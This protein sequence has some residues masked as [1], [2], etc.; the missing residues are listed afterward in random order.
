MKH[1]KKRNTAF[2]F[3]C[4]VQEMSK[5]I[6]SKNDPLK[7]SISSV[8]QEFFNKKSILS[9]ELAIYQEVLETRDVSKETASK[10]LQEARRAHSFL[11]KKA[12]FIKQ[13][14]LI[15]KINKELKPSILMNEISDFKNIASLC[16]ILYD[17]A[18]IKEK[19]FLEEQ[20]ADLLSSKRE[21][22]EENK[23]ND[24]VDPIVLPVAIK[25]FNDKY[26]NSLKTNQKELL[27]RFI[28]LSEGTWTEFILYSGSEIERIK[29]NIEIASTIKE[30][31][32]LQE[33]L[34]KVSQIIEGF[35]HCEV[36]LAFVD[37]LLKLQS[38]EAEIVL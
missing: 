28:N 6:V 25:K 33:E 35:E 12:I 15:Q 10:I 18:S 30:F 20:L 4:L 22:L 26:S 3:E 19:I 14:A 5:A 31:E 23:E 9:K 32:S 17:S 16:Q 21:I 36:N 38:L 1:N 27:N 7:Q 13:V 34:G 2:L 24:L 8:I 11:N 29:K 37:K